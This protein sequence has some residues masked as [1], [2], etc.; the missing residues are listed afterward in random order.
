MAE[1]DQNA[2]NGKKSTMKLL[3]II[4]G[5]VLLAGGVGGGVFYYLHHS[6]N[7]EKTAHDDEE[8]AEKLYYEM[9]KPLTVNFPRGSSIQMIQISLAFLVA[10]K[11]DALEA[12][13]KHEPMIRNN[14]LMLISAQKPENLNMR[15]E[16]EKLRVAMLNE[17]TSILKKMAGKSQVKELFFTAFV[18]Q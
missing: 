6:A 12:V 9:A 8:E 16:K 3:A 18:M 2:G 10:G 7:A 5:A 13:K 4:L 17:V 1:S 14:L 15:E 11:E